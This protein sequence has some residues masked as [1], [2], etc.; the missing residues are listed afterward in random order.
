MCVVNI[1]LEVINNALKNEN[2]YICLY[3]NNVYIYNYKEIISFNDEKIKVKLEN[4]NII[5]KGENL[6][7]KKMDIQELLINGNIESTTYE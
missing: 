4:K 2:Y 5:I 1:M 3:N 6:L 7:I